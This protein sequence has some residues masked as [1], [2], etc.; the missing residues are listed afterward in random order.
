[1]KAMGIFMVGLFLPLMAAYSVSAQ[2]KVS[3]PVFEPVYYDVVQKLMEYEFNNSDVMENANMLCNIFGGRNVKTP[4]YREAAEWCVKRLKEYGLTNAHLE[5]Y[6][7][8]NGWDIEYV[9]V[10]MVAP[11][12]MPII[13]FPVMWSSG[14]TGKIR[15]PAIHINFDEITSEADLESYQGKLKDAVKVYR[16]AASNEKLSA[17]QR[18]SFSSRINPYVSI[19]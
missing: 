14:T 4:A 15:A 9:S 2:E 10:H 16:K 6:E 1:M 19:L 8:G 18:G 5:P 17:Y 7:F 13:G 12:Y 11:K 3:K